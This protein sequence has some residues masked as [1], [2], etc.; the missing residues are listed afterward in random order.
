[1]ECEEKIDL[2]VLNPDKMNKTEYAFVDIPTL[3]KIVF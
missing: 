3:E 2:L 1:M